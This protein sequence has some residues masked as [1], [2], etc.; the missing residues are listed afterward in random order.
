MLYEPI[1]VYSKKPYHIPELSVTIHSFEELCYVIKEKSYDID[2]FLMEEE[3]ISFVR[4]ELAIAELADMMSEARPDLSEYVRVILTYRHHMS[5]EETET[6]CTSLKDGSDAREYIRLISRGDF[7]VENGKYR[8]AILM[9]EHAAEL[10]NGESEK[11]GLTFSELMVKLGRLYS[12]FFNFEKAAECFASAGDERRAFFCRKLSLS[13]VEYSDMLLREH[14]EESLIRQIDEMTN[15]PL[16]IATLRQSL[17]EERSYGRDLAL[18][19]LCSRLKAE[20]RR[21]SR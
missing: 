17:T 16:E 20:Y 19:R 11:E 12:L 21:I 10:L 7:F 5:R 3:I 8:P 13:R 18:S 1:G 15:T 6:V 9:Y 14:P 4:D 2:D